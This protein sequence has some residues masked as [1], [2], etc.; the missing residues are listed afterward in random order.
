MHWSPVGSSVY[1][2]LQA[3]I[4]EWV[5]SPFSGDLPDPGIEPMSPA[6][7]ADSSI[8]G[9]PGGSDG[10]ESAYNASACSAGDPGSIPDPL[11]KGMATHSSIPAWTISW[12][13]EPGKATDHRVTKSRT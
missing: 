12:A 4:L 2:I 9:F 11:E 1:G 5:A 7:Q 13:E 6:L 8:A 10:Q 3:R